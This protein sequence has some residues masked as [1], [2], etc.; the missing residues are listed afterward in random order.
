[1]TTMESVTTL[2]LPR[3]FCNVALLTAS[4]HREPLFLKLCSNCGHRNKF[5]VDEQPLFVSSF[6]KRS[7]Y[8][9]KIASREAFGKHGKIATIRGEWNNGEAGSRTGA[10]GVG[11]PAPS[12]GRT[13]ANL[14]RYGDAGVRV[15]RPR[16]PLIDTTIKRSGLS[17]ANNGA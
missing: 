17:N 8:F 16:G 7:V 12:S 2:D 4:R 9:V 6:T 1:M 5:N 10:W 3:S 11:E 15:S 14:H 13:L